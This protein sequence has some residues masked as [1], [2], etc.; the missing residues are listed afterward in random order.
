MIY[1]CTV[2]DVKKVES[3]TIFKAVSNGNWILLEDVDHSPVDSLS[4]LID[5][6]ETKSIKTS[7]SV[8]YIRPN[9][10]LFLTLR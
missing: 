5:L 8:I 6:L 4:L 1:Y 2:F 9:F 10:R 7:D 3:Y